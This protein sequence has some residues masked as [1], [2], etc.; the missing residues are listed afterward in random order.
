M[1]LARLDEIVIAGDAYACVSFFEDMK[2]PQRKTYAERA[3]QWVRALRGRQYLGSRTYHRLAKEIVRDIE[4]YDS[5]AAGSFD[6]PDCSNSASMPPAQVAMLASAGFTELKKAGPLAIPQ[7]DLAVAVMKS[8]NPAWID[9]WCALILVSATGSHWLALHELEQ[10]GLCSLPRNADYWKAMFCTLSNTPE[11]Y[12]SILLKDQTVLA[13]VW[14]M[15]ADPFVRSLLGDP[16]LYRREVFGNQWE[17]AV[18]RPT[19]KARRDLASGIWREV[20][21]KATTDGMLETNR[22]IELS[23]GFLSEAGEKIIKASIYTQTPSA[24]FAVKLNQALMDGTSGSYVSKYAPLLGAVNKDV[25]MYAATTLLGISEASNYVSEI[26]SCIQPVF[27]HKPKEPAELALKLLS[28][29]ATE[30]PS[31]RKEFGPAILASLNHSSKEVVR[32]ATSLIESSSILEDDSLRKEYML[33]IESLTGME[34]SNAVKLAERFRPNHDITDEETA[35]TGPQ[36]SIDAF[37][38]RASALDPHLRKLAKI[39]LAIEALKN[40]ELVDEPV[41]LDSNLFPRL[42]PDSKLA[43]IENVDDLIFKLTKVFSGHAGVISLERVLDGISRLCTQKPAGFEEKTAMLRDKI[44]SHLESQGSLGSGR[45]LALLVHAWLGETDWLKIAAAAPQ[46]FYAQRCLAIYKR[47]ASNISAPLLAMPT[48]AGGWVDAKI[49]LER[50]AEY[51]KLKIQPDEADYIQ[52]LLRLAPDGVTQIQE[53][54]RSVKGE[55]GKSL[56]FA[57]GSNEISINSM[58]EYWIAAFRAKEPQGTSAEL[59]QKLPFTGPDGAEPAIY[60]F[61]QAAIDFFASD[62]YS[63]WSAGLPNF[64]PVQTAKSATAFGKAEIGQAKNSGAINLM[65]TVLL[66]DTTNSTHYGQDTYNW[67]HNRESLL[68][69]YAKQLL[70]NIDSIGAYSTDQFK[71]LFD[72]DLSM[73]ENGRYVIFLA[74]SSKNNDLSRLA[75]D[76]LIAAIGECRIGARQYGAAM[77]AFLSSKSIT[78]VRWVRGL[79]DTSRVSAMHAHFVWQS[80]SSMIETAGTM[81][82]AQ[83]PFLELLV[84]LQLEHGYRCSEELK[85]HMSNISISGK[86]AKLAKSLCSFSSTKNDKTAASLQDLESRLAR[87]ERWQSWTSKSQKVPVAVGAGAGAEN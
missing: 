10:D 48:H 38:L 47:V 54:A 80:V 18:R 57:L 14:P 26:C 17:D 6:F 44:R 72:P 59:A 23:F 30:K 76:V 62:K 83:I 2:E 74:M 34:R 1:T 43:P 45:G 87:V 4:F 33:R 27:L 49:L 24:E 69:R 36:V 84:E 81:S 79:R 8:R 22:A 20:L 68:A 75:V 51:D 64:L 12:E 56:R 5:I 29:I 50:L 70:C 7:P 39:D 21:L 9:K 32:K 28:K 78:Y 82:T 16:E 86:C 35:N 67:L 15:L 19:P 3:N 40:N 73:N 52:A 53:S 55:I 85:K 41:K 11:L 61:D 66:H 63:S 25:S 37:L 13:E 77:A 65:P 31:E 71:I 58:P 46:S 42:N 60:G